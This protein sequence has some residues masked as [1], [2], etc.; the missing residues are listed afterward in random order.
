V[1]GW[2]AILACAGAGTR[3]G[4]G[5]DKLLVQVGGRP[6]VAWSALALASAAGVDSLTAVASTRNLDAVKA[7]IDQLELRVPVE[8]IV[9]GERRQDSVRIALEHLAPAAP[10]FV[11]I[12]DGARPAATTGVMEACMA[13]ATEFG[14]ATCAVPLS[15]AIKEND[16]KGFVRR[17]VSRAML[18]AIQTPQAF[19]YELLVAAHRAGVDKNLLVDDDAELVERLGLPV[20]IVEGEH[21]NIKVTTPADL[22]V[23]GAHLNGMA[24]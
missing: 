23:A 20:R 16:G 9:G 21:R 1:S 7:A 8:V 24:H 10:G 22:D 11:V 14:A 5:N 13:A 19:R 2:A 17:S 3:M 6:V 18:I 4:G 15:D 12:H